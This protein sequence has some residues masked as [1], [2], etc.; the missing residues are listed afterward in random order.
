MAVTMA[1]V[2]A[3]LDPDEPDY[4]QAAKLGPQ[5]LAHLEK[6]VKE[7]KEEI[8]DIKTNPQAYLGEK[9]NKASFYIGII[10][11]IFLND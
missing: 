1:Q 5:A 2:R 6:L 9:N 10:I 3:V 4:G 7:L 11:L 8:A